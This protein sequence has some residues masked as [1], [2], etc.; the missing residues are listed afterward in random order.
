MAGA[1]AT[2]WSPLPQPTVTKEGALGKYFI[3]T[4]QDRCI[5]CKACEVHCQTKNTLPPDVRFGKLVTSE[6]V[7]KKG[8]PRIFNLFVPC[9]HCDPAW[10][11][12]SCPTGAMTKRAEDG[13]V[14][15]ETKLCVGCKACI[16]ACPWNVP[17]MNEATKKAFK[18]DYCKD[19]LDQGLKPAC[20]NGC[21]AQALELQKTNE[22]AYGK[23]KA[24]ILGAL[25]QKH[26]LAQETTP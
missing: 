22:V 15:V 20:V 25:L 24:L 1:G 7:N 6:P 5:S 14:F 23:R 12:F 4:N 9:F 16:Q 17:V 13:I 11:V 18:C 21:T 8:L 3:K 10:C 2:G 26:R 19:R